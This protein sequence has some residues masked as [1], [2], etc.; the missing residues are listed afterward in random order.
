MLDYRVVESAASLPAR[1]KYRFG[2]GKRLLQQAFGD[3][4][5]REVFTRRKMGFGVPLDAWLRSDLAPLVEE[6]LNETAVVRRGWFRP[7]AVQ[8]LI[9]E[10]RSTRFDH[11]ARIWALIVLESWCRAWSDTSVSAAAPTSLHSM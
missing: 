6:L 2:R 8:R 9:R 3:L 10:H 5:P 11:S 4:L 1:L 7:E